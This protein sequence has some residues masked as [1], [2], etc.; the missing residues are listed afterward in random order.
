M[1]ARAC[2][3]A[4]ILC[5]A[6]PAL[7]ATLEPG[8]PLDVRI[9]YDHSGSMYPGYRPPGSAE[10]RSRAELGVGFF[11]ESPRF[12][13]WLDDFARRQTIVDARTLGMWTFTS[14][15]RFTPADIRQVHPVVPIAAFNAGAAISR[16]P[17]H[18][19][20]RTYLS[21]ALTTFT[22]DFTGLVW[23]ITDNIV[24]TNAGQPDEGVQAFFSMLS[25]RR[26]IRAVHLFK[27][28]F[29]E[30]GQTAAIAV[31]GMLVS[32]Q[33]VPPE[34]LQYYDDKFLL[35]ADAKRGSSDVDLF[36]GRAY[37]KLKDLSIRPMDA[38]L[39]LVLRG[40]EDGLFE[41]GQTVRLD[42]EGTIR[43]YLTQHTV[44]SGRYELAIASAFEPEDW[45]RQK[46]GAEAMQPERFD[47]FSSE[48]GGTIPPAGS[49]AIQARLQSQQ[50]ISFSPHGLGDWLRLAWSGATVRYTGLVRMSFKD[51]RVRLEPRRMAGIFGIDRATSAFAFQ[52]VKTLPNVPPTRVVVSFALRTGRS[53]TAILLTVLAILAAIAAALA[54]LLSR[55]RAFHIAITREP[56]TIIALRPLG[57]YDVTIEG[58]ML[59]RLSRSLGGYGFD[60]ATNDPTITVTPARENGEWDVKVNGTSRRL[61]IKAEGGG[62]PKTKKPDVVSIRAAPPPP[63]PPS[64]PP[65]IGH[66]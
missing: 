57:A 47:P 16:F 12:S 1:S 33:N 5:A 49:R 25:S 24:E 3:A 58:R 46:L 53:R 45:A 41:E 32:P 38:Q 42:I 65:R 31:Y 63:P 52:D 19:G 56:E 44:T 18:A 51:V 43:S 7:A 39:Q 6:L 27:Y 14:G 59:G 21:E 9:L 35:L 54:F 36:P 13:L 8:R 11:H 64:R 22:H 26:D 40:G 30:R 34:T 10:R 17:E 28:T 61:S 37:L 50:P 4:M 23:L 62:K 66:N 60:P 20:N 55:K 48:L 29:E 15:D 2:I